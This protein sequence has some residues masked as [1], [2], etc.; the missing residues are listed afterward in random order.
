MVGGV[1]MDGADGVV[2]VL[3]GSGWEEVV[4]LIC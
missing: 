3:L 1:L 2:A 4:F